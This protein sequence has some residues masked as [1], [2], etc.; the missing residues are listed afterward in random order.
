[1]SMTRRQASIIIGLL[2][3][4]FLII[5]IAS[6]RESGQA[7]STIRLP[8]VVDGGAQ[9]ADSALGEDAEE[10]G[11]IV[12]QGFAEGDETAED[13]DQSPWEETPP[14]VL[15]EMKE[16]L[17]AAVPNMVTT[18][19]SGPETAGSVIN[20]AGQDIQLP[21]N[22][23]V[24]AYVATILCVPGRRCPEVPAY[25]LAMTDSDAQLTIS[26]ES[27]ALID[28][29][30][31]AELAARYR[32]EFQWLV[33]IVDP[34]EEGQVAPSGVRSS[35]DVAQP[36]Y[37]EL[38]KNL[39]TPSGP[40]HWAFF[41]S[42]YF[43]NFQHSYNTPKI[44]YWGT[45]IADISH[46]NAA[47]YA[48]NNER[49]VSLEAATYT[50]SA[51]AANLFMTLANCPGFPPEDG[52][53]CFTPTTWVST[54]NPYNVNLW[55]KATI[56]ARNALSGE[57][58]SSTFFRSI[59]THE[60]G[61]AFSLGDQSIG[62][63]CNNAVNMIMDGVK[64]V[65][66][67][68]TMCDSTT[69]TTADIGAWDD[70]WERG[71]CPNY[72]WVVYGTGEMG[73]SCTD[74]SFSDGYTRFRWQWSTSSNPNTGTWTIFYE[75]YIMLDNGSHVDVPGAESRVL[76]SKVYP[77]NY[78]IHGKYIKTCT[79]PLFGYLGIAGESLCS[80]AVYYPY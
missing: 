54:G 19:I 21:D 1:M 63:Y 37:I 35:L 78:G 75:D 62:G 18:T 43:N 31:D 69:P 66:G 77:N 6:Y 65:N 40:E 73:M 13:F 25:A 71:R 30:Y 47:M 26:Q 7:Q 49:P 44:M 14:E 20:V 15:E 38:I 52:Y 11:G 39:S 17:L 72:S 45:D 41:N 56:Y 3:S 53:G 76:V 64:T 61:H 60:T 24:N 32:A 16:E 8:I 68:L 58:Y 79:R 22:V 4:I 50:T 29:T 55:T 51:S 80:A 9:G 12:A 10:N 33:D 23:Y 67:Q 74:R 57:T 48:W 70:Y 42:Y 28:V 46:P 36:Y 59:L 2:F 27:G 5:G 34:E